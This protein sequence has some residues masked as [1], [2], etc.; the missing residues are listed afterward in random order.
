[1]YYVYEIRLKNKEVYVGC[2]NNLRRR[3]NQ[4]N[5][6]I[7]NKKGKFGIY[8]NKT[9]PQ[10]KLGLVDM[11]GVAIIENRDNALKY[12]KLV[13]TE[14]DKQ[15]NK[16][17]N[18]NYTKYCSRKGKNTGNTTKEYYVINIEK[19]TSEYIK[20]L[21]QYSLANGLSYKSLQDTL[22]KT[23]IYNGEY[24]VFYKE[25][26][27][28][29]KNKSY[30]TSGLFI[31]EINKN[32][33]TDLIKRNAKR[34]EITTPSGEIIVVQNLDKFARENN[35]NSGNLHNSYKSGKKSKGYIVTR[36]I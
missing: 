31:K 13:T 22:K 11:V 26:W 3:K 4:H 7:R 28:C 29:I 14:Y 19:Q 36:R 21:R 5:A 2:T 17:L 33:K 15:G 12:E 25:D 35:I 1:M 9:Y 24:K 10:F 6:N 23:H 34:Y 32:N 20:N 18:D 27:E 16:V 8:V 30:F